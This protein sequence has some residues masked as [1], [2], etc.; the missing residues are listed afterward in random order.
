MSNTKTNKPLSEDLV[1][2]IEEEEGNPAID[3]EDFPE[4]VDDPN[5]L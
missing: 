4:S 1:K 2:Y 3:S 5:Q